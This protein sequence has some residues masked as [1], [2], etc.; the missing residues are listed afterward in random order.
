MKY[1]NDYRGSLK[2]FIDKV[3][4]SSTIN[5]SFNEC[6]VSESIQ[7]NIH[8]SG[9]TPINGTNFKRE[10]LMVEREQL[11][12][13]RLK[14]NSLFVSNENMIDKYLDQLNQLK[15]KKHIIA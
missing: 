1:V 11:A 13:H 14:I 5:T 7:R 8:S 15:S 6:K 10:K 2:N 4:G 9:S 3:L 12:K